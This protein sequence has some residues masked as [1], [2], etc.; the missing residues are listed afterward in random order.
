MAGRLQQSNLDEK[1]MHLVMLCVTQ[2]RRKANRN[3]HHRWYQ[4][5]TAHSGNEIRTL[6][7]WAIQFSSGRSD[8]KMCYM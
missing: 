6:G 3:D 7:Y 8:F 5:K 1:V 4:Q 2:E